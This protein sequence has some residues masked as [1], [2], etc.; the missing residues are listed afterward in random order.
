MGRLLKKVILFSFLFLVAPLLSPGLIWAEDLV[1]SGDPLRITADEYGSMYLERKD[2]G[3]YVK[4]YFQDS[5][6]FLFLN[7]SNLAFDS[8]DPA[9]VG[10][11][12]ANTRFTP[13]SHA[14]DGDWAIVTAYSAGST[15]VQITRTITYTNGDNFYLATYKINNGGSTTYSNIKFRYGGDTYFA[16]DDNSVGNYDSTLKM[17]YLTNPDPSIT[18]R[19][20]IYGSLSD[21]FDHY[22]E[23]VY[24]NVWT[25]LADADTSLPDTVNSNDVDAGYGGEWTRSSLAPGETWTIEVFEKWMNGGHVRVLAPSNR[26]NGPGMTIQYAFT[27][28]NYQTSQDTF[29]LSLSSAGGWNTNFPGGSSVAIGA[30]NSGTATVEVTIPSGTAEGTT[31]VLTLTAT[32]QT[33]SGIT[34]SASTTTTVSAQTA[35]AAA[36]PPGCSD[37]APAIIPE[38]FQ[39]NTAL[40]S[41]T[42]YFT[43]INNYLSYYFIAYGLSEGDERYGVEYPHFPSNGVES[44]TIRALTP[45]TTYYFRVRGGNGC[46]VGGWSSWLSSKTKPIVVPES[47]ISKVDKVE[48]E[49]IK[50]A[51]EEQQI[52]KDYSINVKVVDGQKNPIKGAKIVLSSE[53]RESTTD[54]TGEV[55]F[56]DVEKGK[57]KISVSYKGQLG[58][59]E[60]NVEGDNKQVDFTIELR[61]TNPLTSPSTVA[62][63]IVLL[64]IIGAQFFRT[65]KAK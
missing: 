28:E 19:M 18:W 4:Q 41:A 9:T 17:V 10:G 65:A 40:D 36:G 56:V 7:N 42:L 11:G 27:V 57:H 37:T 64:L 46:A 48:K 30:A 60:I 29:T 5:V 34:R 31:D 24:T 45:N 38:L 39:I 13:V 21:Q 16:G 63:I 62:V 43:P 51:Q 61:Q 44:Y 26:S 12:Y 1:I 59:Q 22:Y 49:E 8:H 47:L 6:S 55:T 58:E 2:S 53:P 50:G 54:E 32:S 23:A 3:S 15:N 52:K 25:S 14:K 33:D 35:L 20:G